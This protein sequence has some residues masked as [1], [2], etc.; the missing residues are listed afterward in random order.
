MSVASSEPLPDFT[1]IPLTQHG[2]FLSWIYLHKCM[3]T[4][5]FTNLKKSTRE[6]ISL[7][8]PY[9]TVPHPFT[10]CLHRISFNQDWNPLCY[11]TVTNPPSTTSAWQRP[12]CSK[13]R[14]Q[15][16]LK[17]FELPWPFSKPAARAQS[18]QSRHNTTPCKAANIFIVIVSILANKATTHYFA[19]N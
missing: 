10:L 16:F 5:D 2:S 19:L 7:S 13:T 3:P 8:V 1:P 15:S 12:W 11:G 18:D 6:L 9:L 17:S 4:R 14:I